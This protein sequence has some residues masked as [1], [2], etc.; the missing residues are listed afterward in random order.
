[1]RMAK[2]SAKMVWHQRHTH[3]VTVTAQFEF[4]EPD[5]GLKRLACEPAGSCRSYSSD[6]PQGLG[7]AR[8]RWA[9][10]RVAS[11]RRYLECGRLG[12][13]APGR[14][15]TNAMRCNAT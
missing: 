12:A 7:P 8:Y 15:T 3:N 6:E 5:G 4:Q 1:M 9:A 13:Q 11:D 14:S 2:F 10:V